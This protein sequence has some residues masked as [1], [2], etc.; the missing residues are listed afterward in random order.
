MSAAE[1]VVIVDESNAILGTVPKADVHHGSTPLHRGFSLFV[2]NRKGE[3]LS[4]KRSRKKRIFPLV[5]T[6]SVSGHPQLNETNEEAAQRRA[7]EELGMGLSA[8]EEITPY[9]YN[10]FHD[11]ILE[12]EICP[13]LIGF[14]DS[15]PGEIDREEIAAVRWMSWDNFRKDMEANPSSYSP[16]CLEEAR[17]LEKHPRFREFR[18]RA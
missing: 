1:H 5:W 8:V 13:I 14:T 6:D 17:I 15:E 18:E 10:V 7:R 2:F 12:N 16:W 11:G 9:R 3:V 4:Q